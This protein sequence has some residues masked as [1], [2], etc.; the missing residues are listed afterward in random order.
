MARVAWKPCFFFETL[1]N[2]VSKLQEMF[3][4]VFQTQ[5]FAGRTLLRETAPETASDLEMRSVVFDL[6]LSRKIEG[7]SARRVCSVVLGKLSMFMHI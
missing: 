5:A 3:P 2:A 6:V 1:P 7:D 4:N